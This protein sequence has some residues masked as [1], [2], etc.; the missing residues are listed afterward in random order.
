MFVLLLC[1][2]V[3]LHVFA[4]PMYT[5]IFSGKETKDTVKRKAKTEII[6]YYSVP[7]FHAVTI[8]GM[9]RVGAVCM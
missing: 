5:D 2:A 3:G 7:F 4:L 6:F 8:M 9:P 1:V